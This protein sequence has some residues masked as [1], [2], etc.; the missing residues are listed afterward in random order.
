MYQSPNQAVL[1]TLKPIDQSHSAHKASGFQTSRNKEQSQRSIVFDDLPLISRV[2]GSVS[3][4]R[5]DSRAMPSSK[6]SV[7]NLKFFTPAS[8]PKNKEA[9]K[10]EE[11]M[12]HF[13]LS[14]TEAKQIKFTSN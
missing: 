11:A 1:K 3:P 14:E 6:S 9:Q 8:S 12:R 2:G 10:N 4:S 5:P 13:L 7:P